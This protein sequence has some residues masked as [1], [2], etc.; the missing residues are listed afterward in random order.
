MLCPEMESLVGHVLLRSLYMQHYTSANTDCILY[1][2]LKD[3]ANNACS[4][5]NYKHK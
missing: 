4:I 3:N 5:Y 2:I 1:K